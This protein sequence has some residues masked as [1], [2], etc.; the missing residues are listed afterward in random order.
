MK[1]SIG[2]DCG[3]DGG[4]VSLD[5]NSL[6]LLREPFPAV[7]AGKGRKVDLRALSDIFSM[8]ASSK[9]E[10]SVTIED[11]GAH[12]PSASGLRSMTYCFAVVEMVCVAHGLRYQTVY[13]QN[14]Q[15][16]FW[17][18]PKMKI[19]RYDDKNLDKQ[20]N[21]KPIREKFDTKAAALMACGRLWPNETW[22]LS[23]RHS[24]PHDGLIDAAL[25]AEYGRLN[26]L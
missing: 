18:R 5:E 21:P 19:I 10:V 1:L 2:V 15:K 26:N 3:L 22:R 7:K 6:I 9:Y 13:A 11:P 12:A 23:S 4:V 24:K 20:G 25:I 17:T 16:H 8:F 14:W